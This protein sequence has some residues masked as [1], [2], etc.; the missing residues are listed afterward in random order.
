MKKTIAFLLALT[1][2]TLGTL[3][4]S[5]QVKEFTIA[6]SQATGD[7]LPRAYDWFAQ[8]LKDRSNGTLSGTCYHDCQLGAQGDYVTS[9][10]LDSIQVAETSTS[11]LG[12]VDGKFMIFDIPYVSSSVEDCQ[13]KLDAGLGDLLSDAL[14]KKCGIV[15]VGWMIRTPRNVYAST[16]PIQTIEDFNGMVI[17]TMDTK[18]VMAAF[19]LL[20]ATPVFISGTERYMALQ[21]GVVDAAENSSAEILVKKEYEVTKYLS[22]T[23]HLIV[24]NP[25]CVSAS[26]F[27]SLTSEEQAL[28][29]E[30][31]H[32]AGLLGTQYEVEGLAKTEEALAE[33]GMK[34]NTI[35]DA[36][37]AKIRA[38]VAPMYEEYFD[39]IGEDVWAYFL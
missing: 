33:V 16:R 32:E 22:L 25:I 6:T 5:A 30:V 19:E 37:R 38:A 3:T 26:W 29:R 7:S 23:E 31:G 15:I 10:Q 9:L 39:I 14:E 4:A 28:V 2:L 35:D 13:A 36:Q 24:P 20:K 21:T 18:P 11:L 1:M 34:I 17:R 12:N 8:E 27:N